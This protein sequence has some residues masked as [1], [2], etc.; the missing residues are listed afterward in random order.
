MMRKAIFYTAGILLWLLVAAMAL[1][2]FERVRVYMLRP[3]VEAYYWQRWG[4]GKER[5]AEID[6]ATRA[7]A[8][9]PL[10]L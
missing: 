4:V 6:A 8:P 3:K 2:A 5:E 7:V 10:A 9:V 1:D